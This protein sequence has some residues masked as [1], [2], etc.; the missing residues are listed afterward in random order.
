MT[1]RMRSAVRY[2]ILSLV[3]TIGGFLATADAAHAH[4]G[5]SHHVSAQTDSIDVEHIKQ[6]HPGHCHGGMTCS[7][8][9]LFLTGPTPPSP[10]GAKKRL[11]IPRAQYRVLGITA[12]DPPPPRVLI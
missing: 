7:V 6:G 5:S 8:V 1:S 12:F 2:I 9:G 4:G 11:S 3:L 10:I